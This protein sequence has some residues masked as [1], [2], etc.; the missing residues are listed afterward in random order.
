MDMGVRRDCCRILTN[1]VGVV[2]ILWT[3]SE[4]N[5]DQCANITYA[6]IIPVPAPARNICDNFGEA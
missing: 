2:T 4:T 3:E 5:G 1:S 6:P